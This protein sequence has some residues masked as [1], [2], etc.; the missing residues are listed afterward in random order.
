MDDNISYN[1]SYF[2]IV[3]SDDYGLSRDEL[4]EILN[5]N[6]ISL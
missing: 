4:V 2:P 3:L 1:Y 6:N 5:E